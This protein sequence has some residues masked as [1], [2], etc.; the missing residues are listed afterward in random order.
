MS[1]LTCP[2]QCSVLPTVLVAVFALPGDGYA[3]AYIEMMTVHLDVPVE[4]LPP[5][6]DAVARKNA[7]AERSSPDN[8][9]LLMDNIFQ[10]R[11]T[12]ETVH[13]GDMGALRWDWQP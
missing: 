9:T 12:K 2:W 6:E 13:L 8:V 7:F 1:R 5:P 4:M 3:N 11:T 10:A